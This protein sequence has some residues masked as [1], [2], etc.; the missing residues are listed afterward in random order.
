[1]NI[2]ERSGSKTIE[3]FR[4]SLAFHEELAIAKAQELIASLMEGSDVSRADLARRLGQSKAHVTNLLSDGRNLTL[5]SLAKVC[6]HL[7]AELS[8]EAEPIAGNSFKQI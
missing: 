7:G 5:R 3:D 6:Y 4:D 2:N 8:L 1:M